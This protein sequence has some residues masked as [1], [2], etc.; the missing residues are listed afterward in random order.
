M[1]A[2]GFEP[3]LPGWWISGCCHLHTLTSTSLLHH[4]LR[5]HPHVQFQNK[6]VLF[7]LP[8]YISA[9]TFTRWQ[10]ILALSI[11]LRRSA[12]SQFIRVR[13]V[14][15]PQS[16]L[17]TPLPSADGRNLPYT[18]RIAVT[19]VSSPF[20][21]TCTQPPYSRLVGTVG[22]EPTSKTIWTVIS[23]HKL[24]CWATFRNDWRQPWPSVAL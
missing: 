17:N 18:I 10:L 11:S 4:L 15:Y 21:T 1:E 2:E 12:Y 24:Y 19:H 14:L 7:G 8:H 20:R 5:T 13:P 16:D 22:F 23:A 3:S 9:D 6:K